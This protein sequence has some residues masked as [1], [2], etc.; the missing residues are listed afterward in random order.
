MIT[1]LSIFLH[2]EKMITK[3]Q[4]KTFK[5]VNVETAEILLISAL[6]EFMHN[7]DQKELTITIKK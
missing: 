5:G 1:I 4:N 2:G 6:K 3:Q 7:K